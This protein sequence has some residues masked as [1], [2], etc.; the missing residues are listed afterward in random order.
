MIWT[1]VG[2]SAATLT[3]FS[4][5]PQAIKI[6]KTKSASDVSLITL[7]QMSSGVLLW[8]FY[9]IHLKDLI[10]IIAN[11]V[12]LTTLVVTMG[13]FFKYRKLNQKSSSGG[14]EI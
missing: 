8:T 5:L 13:L 3:M 4:F 2:M 12:M 7:I 6:L 11:V 10:I 14:G 1:I 9:G